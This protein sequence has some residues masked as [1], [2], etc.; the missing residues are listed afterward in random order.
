MK[1]DL[2]I[3]AVIISSMFFL[4]SF[5]I[6]LTVLFFFNSISGMFLMGISCLFSIF[7]WF[8]AFF[9]LTVEELGKKIFFILENIKNY[10]LVEDRR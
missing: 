4:A 7:F 10:V 3:I 6:P 8:G 9:F 5:L 2:K 1:N